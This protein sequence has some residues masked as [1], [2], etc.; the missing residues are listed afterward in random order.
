[1]SVGDSIEQEIAIEI[2]LRC[3]GELAVGADQL[4]LD[5]FETAATVLDE[6]ALDAAR[7]DSPISTSAAIP[8]RGVTTW[9]ALRGARLGSLSEVWSI[10]TATG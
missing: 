8:A 4:E 6:D 2:T 5:A 9:S 1:M 7:P 10:P 3:A